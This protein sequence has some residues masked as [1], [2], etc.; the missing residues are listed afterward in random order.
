MLF[1]VE[2]RRISLV[3]GAYSDV[4]PYF[5]GGLVQQL[6]VKPNTAGNTFDF[7]LTNSFG[8]VIYQR[9]TNTGTINEVDLN[10]PV[11]G[12]VTFAIANATVATNPVT[13]LLVVKDGA[14]V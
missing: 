5:T 12:V 13:I 7:S 11:T 10:V 2:R 4:T 14:N 6:L 9:L 1:H 8:D 3:A